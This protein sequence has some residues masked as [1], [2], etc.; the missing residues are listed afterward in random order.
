[1]TASEA[2]V[3]LLIVAAPS[4]QQLLDEHEAS[5]GELLPSVFLGEVATWVTRSLADHNDADA[6]TTLDALECLLV[7]G[8]SEVKNLVATGFLEGLPLDSI[9]DGRF[10]A[11]LGPALRHDLMEFG[12]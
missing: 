6:R 4:L 8:D 12:F 9:N 1:M 7:A 2:V 5:N 11:L 3:K 10:R